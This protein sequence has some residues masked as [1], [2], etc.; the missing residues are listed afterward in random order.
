MDKESE[1]ARKRKARN[2]MI[3]KI[4]MMAFA[5]KNYE[6]QNGTF[7]QTWIIS[8]ARRNKDLIKLKQD[9]EERARYVGK[10]VDN[11]IET[12]YVDTTRNVGVVLGKDQY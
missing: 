8:G 1:E 11:K 10:A 9:L 3:E 2:E 6:K 5:G 4:P 12:M 7:V